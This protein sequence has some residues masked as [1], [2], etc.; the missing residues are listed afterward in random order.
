MTLKT[1]YLLGACSFWL[2]GACSS[3]PSSEESGIQSHAFAAVSQTITAQMTLPATLSGAS[4]LVAQ[5]GLQLDSNLTI[6]SSIG[7]AG[8]L[9]VQPDVSVLASATVA[10]N[11]AVADRVAIGVLTLGGN[12]TKGNN[13]VLPSVTKTSVAKVTT[14]SSVTFPVSS[15]SV[16]VN[17]GQSR[18]LDPGAY[19]GVTVSSGATL[20]L[21]A[22][23]YFFTSLT[24]E[25]SSVLKMVSS[26]GATRIFLSTGLTWRPT[27]DSSVVPSR[28]FVEYLG[29]NT[30]VL[31][32]PFAGTMVAPQASLIIGSAS[33]WTQSHR[34]SFMARAIEVQPMAKLQFVAF[35][36]NGTTSACAAGSYDADG[37]PFTACVAKTT[38]AP[39]T[40]VRNEGSTTADRTCAA[41]SAGQYSN[42]NNASVCT[43]W[44]VCQAGTHVSGEPSPSQDRACAPCESG[45]FSTTTNAA[46]C[47]PW[48]TCPAGQV[49]GNTPSSTTDVI[50]QPA[51]CPTGMGPTMQ[52]VPSGYCIDSTEVT[53]GQYAA[54]LATNP[55]PAVGQDAVCAWNQAYVPDATC[56]SQGS[57]CTTAD[58]NDRPAVCVDWCDA[59]AFC[60]AAG[61]RLCGNIA[62]G[63]NDFE[64]STCSD[65][66]KNQWYVAC[67]SGGTRVYPYGN[68]YD[69]TKCESPYD[70]QSSIESDVASHPACQSDVAGYQGIFD[71]S[72]NVWEWEDACTTGAGS[73]F[74]HLRG[75]SFLSYGGGPSENEYFATCARCGLNYRDYRKWTV[76]FR[77]C[78]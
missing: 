64:T 73:A 7:S 63:S 1:R 60:K 20:S 4:L 74:C 55:D 59:A 10:G 19:L 33:G 72:G 66:T 6:N 28:L 40:F 57:V 13:D 15:Q 76:G 3:E 8:T 42:V 11:V 2:L 41:C 58:C 29:S 38:C 51:P 67:S 17:G 50:C 47:T 25:S 78:N 70:Y 30:V 14:S 52:R 32:S 44:T 23:D 61:K 62:G 35:D 21:K 75:G 56:M 69:Q 49:V 18:T 34:G 5:N 39:G 43:P 37:N 53:R 27:V 46:E 22:G 12:L 48:S 71:L 24:M 26:T 16:F 77:C 36:P 9:Y 31:E 54:W 45:F 68:T 65:V